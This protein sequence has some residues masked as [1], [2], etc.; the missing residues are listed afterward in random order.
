MRGEI[1]REKKCKKER[2]TCDATWQKLASDWWKMGEWG[3]HDFLFR[4]HQSD[5]NT[6]WVEPHRAPSRPDIEYFVGY[7]ALI[8]AVLHAHAHAH[9][10]H[11]TLNTMPPH[12]ITSP[13]ST[14]N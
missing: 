7:L 11:H 13:S 14:K 2:R 6:Y 10:P 4:I 9:T 1:A 12:C 8:L 3:H 5:S